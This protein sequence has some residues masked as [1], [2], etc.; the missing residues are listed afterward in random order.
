VDGAP[1]PSKEGVSK[2]DAEAIFEEIDRR[3]RQ[4]RDQVNERPK[5]PCTTERTQSTEE[6]FRI[7]SVCCVISVLRS[8]HRA[9]RRR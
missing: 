2:A 1:S 5:Q 7:L 6:S 8:F 4:G 3:R 9:E